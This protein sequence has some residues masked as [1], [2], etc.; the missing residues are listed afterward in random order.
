MVTTTLEGIEIV[1]SWEDAENCWAYARLSIARFEHL[2][3][4]KIERARSLALG[5]FS[6]A[7]DMAPDELAASLPLYIQALKP[8]QEAMGDPLQVVYRGASMALRTEIPLRIQDLLAS[9]QLRADPIETPL[10]Q[11][12]DLDVPLRVVAY[13]TDEQGTVRTVKGLPLKFAFAQGRGDLEAGAW[14]GDGGMGVSRLRRIRSA[15]PVQVVV[16][17]LD[18]A[19]QPHPSDFR[20]ALP[21]ARFQLEVLRRKVYIAS[22]ESNL[23]HPLQ[24]PC[25][26]PLLKKELAACGLGFVAQLDQADL[27]IEI[28]ARTRE[29]QRFRNIFFSFLDMTFSISDPTG[30]EVFKSSLN[31]I[32]GS[33]TDYSQAGLRAFEKAG[34]QLGKSLLSSMPDQLGPCPEQP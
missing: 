4:Q 20:F 2:R 12:A 5:L 29:G 15:N 26:E 23:G 7:A 1:D 17:E 30:D 16:A 24:I 27:L 13:S 31:N 8:M 10:K 9:I 14:T 22:L 19:L 25:L 18:L 21:R 33:G 11:G 34:K 32:K 6:R 3:Q 28:R